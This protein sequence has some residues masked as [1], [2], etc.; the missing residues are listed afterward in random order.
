MFTLYATK[1][2]SLRRNL[3]S[4]LINIHCALGGI[5]SPLLANIALHGM[6]TALG[7]KYTKRNENITKYPLCFYTDDF[8]IM[9]KIREDAESLYPKL[10]NYL[11]DR[12]LTLAK[13]KARITHITEGFNFLGFKTLYGS[14]W[15]CTN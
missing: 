1:P 4:L 6:E 5:I 13:E 9:C 12:G 7:I 8:I 3:H 15:R 10:T 14:K 2:E 11:L